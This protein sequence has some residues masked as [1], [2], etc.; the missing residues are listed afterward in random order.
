MLSNT[1]TPPPATITEIN[2]VIKHILDA[3]P[4]LTH[5]WITGEITSYKLYG[6][7]AYLTL[8]DPD[9]SLQCV[10]YSNTLD[11]LPFDPKVGTT[12]FAAGKVTYFQKKGSLT[13]QINYMTTQGAG[14]LSKEFEQLKA[15]LTQEGLFDPSR[16]TVLPHYPSK[17]ALITGL[18][19]AAMWD[20]VTLSKDRMP[21]VKL[22]V[23]PATVQGPTAPYSIMKAID[24]AHTIPD[25]DITVILRG[26]GAKEDL[27]WFNQED[28]VRK[29]A[30]CK[31]PTV[32]AI[33]HD[34]D[35]TLSDLASDTST[36]TPSAAVHHIAQYYTQFRA[37]LPLELSHQL[38]KLIQRNTTFKTQVID[39]LTYGKI[40]LKNRHKT[41]T[42]IL[43]NLLERAHA[44]SPLR[45]LMQGYSIAS[46]LSSKKLIKSVHDVVDQDAITIQV[47]DGQTLHL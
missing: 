37:Q 19:S 16:K 30:S 25:I 38:T 31:M 27:A 10:M 44:S 35:H 7:M 2:T 20:F 45:K 21:H 47:M 26:G 34:I 14:E 40:E 3:E 18:N 17:I 39:H 46:N 32:T 28:I 15:K 43:T 33:G 29:I 11:I 5:I 41:I 9:S 24:A 6:R 42:S 4:L 22:V 13:F 23:I 36:A 8:S 1:N 12:V